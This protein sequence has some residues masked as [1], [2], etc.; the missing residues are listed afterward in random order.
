MRFEKYDCTSLRDRLNQFWVQ[1]TANRIMGIP[2]K[3]HQDNVNQPFLPRFN[4]VTKDNI[5]THWSMIRSRI[6]HM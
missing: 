6:I 2:P 1:L 4:K 5:R 3:Q